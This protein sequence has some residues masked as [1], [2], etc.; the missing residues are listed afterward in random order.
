M[1]SLDTSSDTQRALPP[2]GRRRA[3]TLIIAAA[4]AA[5]SPAGA[6]EDAAQPATAADSRLASDDVTTPASCAERY[7]AA[8]GREVL[9]KARATLAVADHLRRELPGMPGYWLFWDGHGIAARSA[10]QQ[11]LLASQQ[12]NRL[13]NR[14]CVRSILARGGRIR[15]L[16]WQ[17]IPAGYKPPPPIVPAADPSKP[18]IS[19]T[20]RRHAAA[21]GARVIGKGALRELEHGTAFYHMAQRTSDELIA[22][23]GQPFRA[24]L[25]TGANEL[26]AFYRRQLEPL[27][28]RHKRARR[29]LPDT[30]Q[31][32]VAATR[33]AMGS[34]KRP[35]SSPPN[36]AALIRALL[37]PVLTPQENDGLP[38]GDDALSILSHARDLIGDQRF[39]AMPGSVRGPLRK[40]LRNIEFALYARVNLNR[41]HPLAASY[42]D[43]LQAIRSAHERECTCTRP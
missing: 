22:F 17:P 40:A 31:A 42:E 5:T 16:K 11:R 13:E 32:A 3:A 28:R 41:V 27:W 2:P 4:L 37:K 1:A 35:A 18:D 25:C 7:H 10:R 34:D 15:C 20:E 26:I 8:L 14:M 39:D 29:L 23:A 33:A 24:S 9:P 38:A 19:P 12:I 21:L 30:R 36:F 6:T 43:A